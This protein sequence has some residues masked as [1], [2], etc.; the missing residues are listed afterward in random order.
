MLKSAETVFLVILALEAAAIISGN[1]FTIF[2]FWTQRTHLKRTCFLLINLAV[3][4]L[5]VGITEPIILGSGNVPGLKA[6]HKRGQ[7]E[8]E[9]RMKNPSS[10]FQVLASSTSVVFLALIS[11]ERAHAVLRPIR[12]RVINTRVFICAIIITWT[13]GF[14]LGGADLLAM[15]HAKVVGS[16]TVLVIHSC[17]FLS[18]LIICGSYLA[19]RT[20]LRPVSPELEVHKRKSAEQNLKLTRTSS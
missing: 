3:A 8:D 18:V 19:I 12:H 4:D 10:V 15:Y 1:M 6:D 13:A 20:R 2:I 16:F 7:M 17:L 14:C 9:Q 11:L 5:P